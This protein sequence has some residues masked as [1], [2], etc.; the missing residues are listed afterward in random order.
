MSVCVCV[1]VCVLPR[2]AWRC[3]GDSQSIVGAPRSEPVH[4]EG[5]KKG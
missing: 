3:E 4:K 5:F 2:S 1:S